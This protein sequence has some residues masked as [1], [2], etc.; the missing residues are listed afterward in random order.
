MK[1]LTLH[2]NPVEEIDQYRQ[3]I[4]FNLDFLKKLD[5]VVISLT[6][7]S[8]ASNWAKLNFT[9]KLS[10]E[11]EKLHKDNIEEQKNKKRKI[12]AL[13]KEV[14]KDIIEQYANMLKN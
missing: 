7:K 12:Q 5:T 11:E 8:V 6:E 13:K 1:F 2:N 14:G 9:G 10:P 4:I 3:R